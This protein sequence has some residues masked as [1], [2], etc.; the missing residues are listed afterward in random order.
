MFE[1]SHPF[2]EFTFEDGYQVKSSVGGPMFQGQLRTV[3]GT[4]QLVPRY[5]SD[6]SVN[7]GNY[8]YMFGSGNQVQDVSI[9][10]PSMGDVDFTNATSLSI[11]SVNYLLSNAP[12]SEE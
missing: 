11:E 8:S 10:L 5:A 9:I 12:E 7:T 4:L 2:T 6:G 1:P 3:H